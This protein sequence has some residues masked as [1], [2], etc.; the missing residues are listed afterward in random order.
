[1]GRVVVV[2]VNTV[3]G[4]GVPVVSLSQSSGHD[5]LDQAALIS[6]AAGRGHGHDAGK[7]AWPPVLR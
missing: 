7:P 5:I 2:V 4:V 3:A 6:S 1:M